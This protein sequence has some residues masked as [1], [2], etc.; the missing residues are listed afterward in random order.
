MA[1]F[2]VYNDFPASFMK[3]SAEYTEFWAGLINDSVSVSDT[4]SYNYGRPN[5]RLSSYANLPNARWQRSGNIITLVS[6]DVYFAGTDYR[7]DGYRITHIGVFMADPSFRKT[8]GIGFVEKAWDFRLPA[9]GGNGGL[10][11]KWN[12][13]G[14]VS[15]ELVHG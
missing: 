7:N 3:Y 15:I 14:I 11:L 6:N 9:D 8:A 2:H 13:T 5:S 10:R 4:A 12:P 1:T